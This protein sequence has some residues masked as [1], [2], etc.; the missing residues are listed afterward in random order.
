[1]E[2]NTGMARITRWNAYGREVTHDAYHWHETDVEVW[3]TEPANWG[4]SIRRVG[5]KLWTWHTGTAAE[6]VRWW[7]SGENQER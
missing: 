7:F 5:E 2:G 1:M 6:A 3:D 4:V